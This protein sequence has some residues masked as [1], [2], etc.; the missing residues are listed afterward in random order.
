M[1]LQ[2]PGRTVKFRDGTIVPALGQ[3]SWHLAQGRHP[4]AVE[5]EAL[6]TGISLGMSLI[7]TAEMYSDG[8]SEELNRPR[9]RRPA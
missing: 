6:R 5:Q 4:E 1:G 2:A 3:G 9:D 8:R 7:D